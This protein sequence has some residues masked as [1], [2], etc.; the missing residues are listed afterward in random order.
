MGAFPELVRRVPR[1]PGPAGDPGATP[2]LEEGVRVLD[3]EIGLAA[4]GTGFAIAG[5]EEMQ[6][7]AVPFGES[8]VAAPFIGE[9]GESE[10]PVV[11]Q[12]PREIRHREDGGEPVQAWWRAH[13]LLPNQS[14][15]LTVK[16]MWKAGGDGGTGGSTRVKPIAIFTLRKRTRYVRFLS[17]IRSGEPG[18]GCRRQTVPGNP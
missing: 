10:R 2:L 3:V 15:L 17:S 4:V 9:G 5:R 7:D 1:R 12:G 13:V 14:M 16:S 8:V 11:G 18:G 6:P